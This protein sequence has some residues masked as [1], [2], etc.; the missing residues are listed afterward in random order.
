MI[1]T[2]TGIFE[3]NQR[4]NCDR[5]MEGSRSNFPQWVFSSEA[6][7]VKII[8]K[9]IRLC[10]KQDPYS[11]P[12]AEEIANLLRQALLNL[13]EIDSDQPLVRASI[14]ELPKRYS[15]SYYDD[16]CRDANGASAYG[17]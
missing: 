2:G 16:Y 10:W 3:G 15:T 14:P 1:L 6:P 4:R 11:R 12:S 8:L 7:A 9:A 17:I 5:L 13:E